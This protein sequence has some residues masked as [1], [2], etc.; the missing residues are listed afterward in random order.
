MKT[1]K[2]L[3]LFLIAFHIIS[4]SGQTIDPYLPD[5]NTPSVKTGMTLIWNDEFNTDGA[6]NSSNWKYESGFVR[7]NELEYYQSKN[8]TCTGGVLKIIGK[9]DTVQNAY[10]VKGSTD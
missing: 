4:I 7:N 3:I 6:P 10:Y 2:Y 5:N 1:S 8:A 9:R